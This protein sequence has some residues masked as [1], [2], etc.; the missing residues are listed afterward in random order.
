MLRYRYLSRT[1]AFVV[2]VYVEIFLFRF[3]GEV[4][5]CNLYRFENSHGSFGVLIEIIP[6]EMLEIA[7][8]DFGI[9]LAYAYRLAEVF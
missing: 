5:D 4:G 2:G 3:I 6:Y 8:F 1:R 9:S 7:Y